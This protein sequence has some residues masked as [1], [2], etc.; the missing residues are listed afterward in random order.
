[1]AV[2]VHHPDESS[3]NI[4]SAGGCYI[5][6]IN[7]LF[8]PVI[9]VRVLRGILNQFFCGCDRDHCRALID[10]AV[11]KISRYTLNHTVDHP[12][13]FETTVR[14]SIH[15]IRFKCCLK[16]CD[17][18]VFVKIRNLIQLLRHIA[19]TVQFII[20]PCDI[21]I[22]GNLAQCIQI[23]FTERGYIYLISLFITC[24]SKHLLPQPLE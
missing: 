23:I 8:Q 6:K 20:P 9:S 24:K 18:R 11:F 5:C 14:V 13:C 1:M 12:F 3:R 7:I 21:R 4:A 17:N 10:S 16:L 19:V 15:R 22:T 2:S